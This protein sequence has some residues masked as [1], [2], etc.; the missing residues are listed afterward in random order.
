VKCVKTLFAV[1]TVIIGVCNSVRLLQLLVVTI[2]KWSI[3]I[4]PNPNKTPSTVTLTHENVF[5]YFQN[6]CKH[7]LELQ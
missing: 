1:V 4:I 3:N 6:E 5:S 7:T 2:R